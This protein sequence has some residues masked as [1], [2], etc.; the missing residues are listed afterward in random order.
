MA[1]KQKGET[2]TV[3][4]AEA[5]ASL[6]SGDL[7]DA[8]GKLR[9]VT[10]LAPE[11]SAGYRSLGDAPAGRGDFVAAAESYSEALWL[12][13]SSFEAANGLAQ[14]QLQAGQTERAVAAY[15][16]AIRLRSSSAE[17]HRQLGQSLVDLDHNDEALI[18][19]EEALRL[20]PGDVIAK[21]ERDRSSR[22]SR[23]SGER[24]FVPH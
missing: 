6:V 9:L 12:R 16:D 3:L 8:V 14:A 5:R 1:D 7:D 11:S 2:A 21:A 4:M 13:P 20:D 24:S 10:Q 19:F 18:A 22:R 17:T 15:R 23:P